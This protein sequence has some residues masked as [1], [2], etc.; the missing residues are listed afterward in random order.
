MRLTGDLAALKTF[1]ALQYNGRLPG[2]GA[3]NNIAQLVK[4]A[5]FG[6]RGRIATPA[7][8]DAQFDA[9]G[10]S[11]DDWFRDESQHD[12]AEFARLCPE[13]RA[14]LDKDAWTLEFNVLN[15]SGGVDVVR[16]SGTASPLTLQQVNIDVVKPRGEFNYPLA[17]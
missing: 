15:S 12:P 13:I 16:A 1:L 2:V 5:T 10:G 11:I 7:F 9:G 4:D 3:L 8:F 17:D 6:K 14:S